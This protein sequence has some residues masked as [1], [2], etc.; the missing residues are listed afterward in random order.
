[1]DTQENEKPNEALTSSDAALN[2]SAKN[3]PQLPPQNPQ[4]M[5]KPFLKKLL[6]LS[7]IAAFC[8]FFL[9]I[10]NHYYYLKD[11]AENLSNEANVIVFIDKASK[12]DAAVCDAIEALNLAVID[13]YV[14]AKDVYAKAVEENPFLKDVSVQ[15]MDSSF[16]SYVK[17]SP[18]ELPTE[19]F[20]ADLRNQLYKIEY[21]DDV[22][23]DAPLFKHYSQI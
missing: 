4:A 17:I 3:M 20:M 16:Q 10:A 11:Y 5:Q 21:I 1:M 8:A 7:V 2:Q 15:G 18:K 12:D 14:H 19:E 23:F 9:L 6:K 22:I 13:E